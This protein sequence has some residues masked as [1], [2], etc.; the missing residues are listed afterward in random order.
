MKLISLPSL[1]AEGEAIQHAHFLDCF[2]AAL[3]AMTLVVSGYA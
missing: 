2:G 3:L 1:R